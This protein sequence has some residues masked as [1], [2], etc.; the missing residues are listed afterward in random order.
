M[1]AVS[2]RKR[3]FVDVD[4]VEFKDAVTRLNWGK[5]VKSWN[6]LPSVDSIFTSIVKKE[7]F[8]S[9]WFQFAN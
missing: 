4:T 2:K 8:A 5:I 1:F 9:N 7:D 3:D 6:D